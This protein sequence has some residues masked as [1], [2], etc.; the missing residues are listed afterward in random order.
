MS[1]GHSIFTDEAAVKFLFDW[2]AWVARFLVLLSRS[3]R[4]CI[5]GEPDY[6]KVGPIILAHWH[7]DDLALLPIMRHI[8]AHIMVSKSRDG[9]YLS[10]AFKVLGY[11]VVR[12]SSSRGGAEA[13]LI[14]KKL[15]DQGQIVTFAAD[16]P[17]GP[18][19]VAKPGPAFLSAK[20][21]CP[22]YPIGVAIERCYNFKATWNKTR[23]PLPRTREV[24][25]FGPPLLLP[26]EA[27]TWPTHRKCRLVSTAIADAVRR[28]ETELER[29]RSQ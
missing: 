24:I 18:R 8:P 23:L 2:P 14:M 11:N 16:G 26:P 3:I 29:W 15:L 6:T 12:G 4:L 1:C 20:T 22:I 28:A 21:A 7:G 25:A 17:R 27:T 5:V 10:R 13:L 9:E 19:L